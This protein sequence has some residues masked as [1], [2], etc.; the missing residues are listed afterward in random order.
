MSQKALFR[1][2]NGDA[3]VVAG[4][5]DSEYTHGPIVAGRTLPDKENT[6]VVYKMGRNILELP[7]PV[8]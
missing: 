2:V 4:G 8:S 6:V 5:F 7:I 3:G 1:V